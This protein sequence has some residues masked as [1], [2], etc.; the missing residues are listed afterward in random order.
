MLRAHEELFLRVAVRNGLMKRDQA[1]LCASEREANLK[2]G[3]GPPVGEIAVSLGFFSTKAARLIEEYV[4]SKF[5]PAGMRYPDG[6]SDV[7][8]AVGSGGLRE[9]VEKFVRR[10]IASRIHAA[11][12]DYCSRKG[13]NEVNAVSVAR[14][15]KTRIRDVLRVFS[16]W[17]TCGLMRRI[18][19]FVDCFSPLPEDAADIQLFLSAW[20]DPSLRAGILRLTRHGTR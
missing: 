12:L 15:L 4:R 20:R 8:L 14:A 16:D 13:L 9:R 1:A 3:G 18:S 5:P 17:E 6:E 7:A 2:A 10:A 11:V 19:Q